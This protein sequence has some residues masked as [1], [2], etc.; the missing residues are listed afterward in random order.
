MELKIIVVGHA[1]HGKDEVAS[2]LE[3]ELGLMNISAT[4]ILVHNIVPQSFLNDIGLSREELELN[5]GQYRKQLFNFVRQYNKSKNRESSFIE[6]VLSASDIYT[7]VRA[8]EELQGAKDRAKELG[9][10][11]VVIWVDASK[12]K[13]L[14]NKEIMSI[15]PDMADIIIDNNSDKN[16]LYKKVIECIKEEI[17]Q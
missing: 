5:K 7:G 8:K 17:I 9:W 15:E 10:N 11:L 2:I 13:P 6:Y 16:T 14:E 1:E 3:L 4:H 12:R